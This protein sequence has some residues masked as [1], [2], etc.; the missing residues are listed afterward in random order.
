MGQGGKITV[1]NNTDKKF[2]KTL[3]KDKH[4]KSWNFPNTIEAGTSQNIYVEWRGL[5]VK[6]STG[7]VEYSVK[8][9]FNSKFQIQA[10][11]APDL[12]IEVYFNN[13]STR[14]NP[15]GSIISLG[16]SRDGH[17]NFVLSGREGN[18]TSTN[19]DGASWMQDHLPLFG[20]VMLKEICIPGSHDAGMS[21]LVSGTFFAK[22]GN[23]LTQS[24]SVAGQLNLGVR[25]F[26]I[27]PVIT[28][29]KFSTGHYQFVDTIKS[30]QGANG[31]TIQSIISDV[32]TFT[33]NKKELVIL[34][35]SHSLNT[36]V[37]NKS[38][39]S[40]NHNEW[41]RLLSQ[42]SGLNNLFVTSR[43]ADL[44]KV[45]V[46]DF[47][48]NKSSVVIVVDGQNA[49]LGDHHGRGFYLSSNFS[50]FDVYAESNKVDVMADDQLNKMKHQAGKRYFL[51]S[52][53][54]TQTPLEATFA[55]STIENMAN[56]ANQHLV[57]YLYPNLS[58]NTF[59]NIIHTDYVVDST[60]ATMAMAVNW[61]K[62]M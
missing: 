15:K 60:P 6:Q 18:Y 7:D 12:N 1:V 53:T 47:I 38:Y 17:V 5:G 48:G 40:F 58:K 19:M 45:K 41:N 50:V 54:L 51:L 32:N 2:V 28:A 21:T 3:Q 57:H 61:K 24:Y 20:D 62:I 26:D 36:D 16:W 29:G 49:V 52:W 10:R 35:V 59:P 13:L 9:S 34:G 23:T 4:M 44:T 31:Q 25:Y 55:V 42:L 33:A 56:K 43:N 27:R 39:R 11:A 22:S 14:N 37:G 30:W 46:R 8:D